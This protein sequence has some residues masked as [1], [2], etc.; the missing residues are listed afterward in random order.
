MECAFEATF[1][2]KP[3]TSD[4]PLK[5]KLS[6]KKAAQIAALEKWATDTNRV[7]SV[8]SV[9][10]KSA[11]VKKRSEKIAAKIQK[12]VRLFA[13]FPGTKDACSCSTLHL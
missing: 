7:T 3:S 13:S 11:P 8:G 1:F 12:T 2:Q 4:E 6:D 5:P 9:E 10:P